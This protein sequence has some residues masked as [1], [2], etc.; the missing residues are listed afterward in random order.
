MYATGNLM[1]NKGGGVK[2]GLSDRY[3]CNVVTNGFHEGIVGTE[4]HRLMKSV[5]G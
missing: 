4:S 2:M 1:G 5:N 3:R